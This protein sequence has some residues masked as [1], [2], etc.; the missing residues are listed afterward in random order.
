MAAFS[1]S[2]KLKASWDKGGNL[3]FFFFLNLVCSPYVYKVSGMVFSVACQ[4]QVILSTP[5]ANYKSLV[6][7]H[8]P[9]K[10]FF[11]YTA[12]HNYELNTRRIEATPKLQALKSNVEIK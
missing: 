12:Q 10:I 9:N 5:V 3:T 1:T 6:H 4:T 11:F 7:S 8:I 2:R